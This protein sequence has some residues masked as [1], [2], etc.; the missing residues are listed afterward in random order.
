MCVIFDL[1]L[2]LSYTILMDTNDTT[3]K[4]R[5]RPP[6]SPEERELRR[7]ERIKI[8][9]E[10]HKKTGN[11][12]QKKYRQTNPDKIRNLRKNYYTP[13]VHIHKDFVNNFNALVEKTGLGISALF[14]SALEEKYGIV[15]TKSLDSPP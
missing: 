1:N 3:K 10:Y 2:L 4:G 5:G 6:L 13:K 8:S 12:A 14:L 15:L 7:V 11:I 9:N